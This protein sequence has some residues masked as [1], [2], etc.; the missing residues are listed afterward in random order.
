[1]P[2]KL[3]LRAELGRQQ[4]GL[5]LSLHDGMRPRGYATEP[6]APRCW[7]SGRTCHLLEKGI[8]TV[9]AQQWAG[10]RCTYICQEMV[11]LNGVR[12]GRGVGG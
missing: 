7:F 11:K 2:P 9:N 1:M 12:R 6:R 8:R 3:S 10:R 4:I 5:L